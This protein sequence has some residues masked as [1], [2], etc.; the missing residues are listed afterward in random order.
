MDV[1][2]TEVVMSSFVN[3][4]VDTPYISQSILLRASTAC[5][6]RGVAKSATPPEP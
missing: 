6:W 3:P 2:V 4:K 1:A 5:I